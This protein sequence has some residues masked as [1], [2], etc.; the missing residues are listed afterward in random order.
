MTPTSACCYRYAL[1]PS[2]TQTQSLARASD[3][4][5]RLW[6]ELVALLRWAES[7]QRHGRREALLHA[8]GRLLARKALIGVAYTKAR[9]LMIERGL[10]NETEAIAVAR[11][12]QVEAARRYGYRRLALTYAIERARRSAKD[13]GLMISAKAIEAVARRFASAGVLYVTSERG[14]PRPKRHGSTVTIQGQ[15]DPRCVSPVDFERG[16]VDLATLVGSECCRA[17]SAVLHRPLPPAAKIK[18]VA[19]VATSTGFSLILMVE[20]PAAAFLRPV[21]VLPAETV[22]GIDP[23]RGTALTVSDT[24]GQVQFSLKPPL[25]QDTRFLKKTRRLKRRA[26]RQIR[27]A[28]PACFDE[29]G[30]WKKTS[31]ALVISRGLRKVRRKIACRQQHL[32]DARR[33]VYQ[34]GANRLLREFAV[35]GVGDWRGTNT[36]SKPDKFRRAQNRKDQGNAVGGFT[37]MLRDKA[38]RCSPTR[39]VV[40]VPEANTTRACPDCG[41]LSGPH[42]AKDLKV[43]VWTCMNCGQTHQ[44]DFASARAIA[45]RALAQTAAGAQPAQPEPSPKEARTPAV[46]STQVSARST[47]AAS[48]SARNLV[49][50][51]ERRSG[52]SAVLAPQGP[53]ADGVEAAHRPNPCS[54]PPVWQQSDLPLV[55][56]DALH[57]HV[58]D[59]LTQA[60]SIPCP[61]KPCDSSQFI[62]TPR[63]PR[64]THPTTLHRPTGD[65][66]LIPWQ[67]TLQ[68]G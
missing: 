64:S 2:P 50:E 66:T 51:P 52:V 10:P 57:A 34:L 32:A 19:V 26:D 55:F 29:R 58:E 54:Q 4:A 8:Y 56:E 68:S 15:V 62:Q 47:R 41:A 37:K 5:R 16:T 24:G 23:G 67:I 12:E 11:T 7:E 36:A 30:H 44:R 3:Q 46:P 38:T 27:A 40:D 13:K 65:I 48:S 43:R 21:P 9:R 49:S 42:G 17:V 59:A 35:V 20:A 22:A 61:C 14:Q 6:N 33:E 18:Q 25:F 60:S 53:E 28:N 1:R 39:L 31:H 63:N 45:R